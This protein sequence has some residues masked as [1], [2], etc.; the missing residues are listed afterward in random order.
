M[1]GSSGTAILIS[2]HAG[3]GT[4][5]LVAMPSVSL[6]F[7]ILKVQTSVVVLDEVG[8]GGWGKGRMLYWWRERQLQDKVLN[9]A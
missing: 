8:G 7:D 3:S 5:I 4:H 6:H 1:T 2:G 9:C